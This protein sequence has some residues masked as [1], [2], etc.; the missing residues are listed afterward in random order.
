MFE[1]VAVI[2]SFTAVA[3]LAMLVGRLLGTLL[4]I[5]LV[6]G[7]VYLIVPRLGFNQTSLCRART[8]HAKQ[9]VWSGFLCRP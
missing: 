6:V 2:L 9:T 4:K 8:Q 3:V 5:T 7:V 1:A